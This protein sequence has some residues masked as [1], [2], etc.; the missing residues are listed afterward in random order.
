MSKEFGLRA[1]PRKKPG[2]AQGRPFFVGDYGG[3]SAAASL[4]DLTEKSIYAHVERRTIPFIRLGGRILFSRSALIS[5]LESLEGCSA[6]E[7]LNNLEARQ[8]RD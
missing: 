1:P 5:F 6:E 2:Q 4:L 3:V 8:G 7:A